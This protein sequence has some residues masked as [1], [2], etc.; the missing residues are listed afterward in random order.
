MVQSVTISF[1]YGRR[2][3]VDGVWFAFVWE[4]SSRD[5]STLIHIYSRDQRCWFENR[6][7]WLREGSGNFGLARL[8]LRLKDINELVA[9]KNMARGCKVWFLFLLSGFF[10]FGFRVL[11]LPQSSVRVYDQNH[12]FNLDTFEGIC[13]EILR[14]WVFFFDNQNHDKNLILNCR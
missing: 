5:M 13:L 9:M 7:V 8:L 4:N 11:L 6:Q 10:E 3:L 1:V 14:N 12:D 2:F